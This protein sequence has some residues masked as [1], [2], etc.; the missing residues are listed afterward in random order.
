MRRL[1]LAT[2]TIAITLGCA[3][4]GDSGAQVAES[5]VSCH[6]P[7]E[8]NPQVLVYTRTTGFRHGSIPAGVQAVRRLG[9]QLGFGVAHT[10]DPEQFSAQSLA[11]FA[12]VIFL[13]TTGDILDDAQQG[14]F[15]AFIQRGGGFVG[16]HSAADTEYDW[17]WYGQLVGAWFASHPRIQEGRLSV[18]DRA[19]PST[20]CLSEPW[21]R[22]DEWYDFRSPPPEGTSILLT[23]DETSYDGGGMGSLH[24]MAWA[25]EVAG[26]R[27][28]YTALGHTTE[29]YSEP[30]FLDHLAGGIIWAVRG[31][32]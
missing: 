23:I 8:G 10:E 12:A 15:E 4:P 27:A 20:R 13:N 1:L 32:Q 25:R 2:T 26:G 19:H 18:P 21:V 7:V 16:V 22:V 31:E 14:A 5:W 29:S 17:P 6:Q 30:A 11:P 28:W 3:A 9:E 24:P